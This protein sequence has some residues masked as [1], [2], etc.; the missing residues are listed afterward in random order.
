METIEAEDIISIK[1][2][3]QNQS[4]LVMEAKFNYDIEDKTASILEDERIVKF[5]KLNRK[6]GENLKLLYGYRCQICGQYVG[7]EYGAKVAE[8]HHIDYFVQSL[9]NDANNQLIVCPNHH[10]I[11]HRPIRYLTERS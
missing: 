1:K 4:E 6:I 11:I 5:R 10:S 9:N 2:A 3:V 8:A 7:A